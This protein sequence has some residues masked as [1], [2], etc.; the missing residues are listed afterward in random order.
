MRVKYDE[1]FKIYE[2]RCPGCNNKHLIPNYDNKPHW[3]FNGDFD[4]PTFTP[5]VRHSWSED[6]V[7]HYFIKDGHIQ[8]C[9]DCTHNMSGQIV[10]LPEL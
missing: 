1:E 5:S 8:Y 3:D 4:R 6:K 10:E 2:H 7:C 9:N